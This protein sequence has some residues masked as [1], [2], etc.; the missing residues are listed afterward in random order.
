MNFLDFHIRAWQLDKASIKVI[1]HCSPVGNMR[2][3]VTIFYNSDFLSTLRTE[4]SRYQCLGKPGTHQK[5]I[6]LGRQL[7][8][9]LFPPEGFTLLIRSLEKLGT[10]NGLRIRLCLDESLIDLPWEFLYR[11]D[12]PTCKP[13]TGFLVLNPK[14]S[15]V[16]EAP[17]VFQRLTPSRQQERLLFAGT[18]TNLGDGRYEDRFEVEK[19]HDGISRAL[20]Q[21]KEFLVRDFINPSDNHIETAL[22]EPTAI[23]HYSGHTDIAEEGGYLVKEII[24]SQSISQSLS[25]EYLAALL[26][27][28]GTK[29]AVFSACNS[30]RWGFVEPFIRA[31]IPALIGTQGIVS[32]GACIVFFR[33]L[34]Y[35]LAIGLSLDEA[36]ILARLYLSD[37]LF[38]GRVSCLNGTVP[39]GRESCDWGSFMV[40]M[41]AVDAYLLPKPHE[42]D[43]IE[44]QQSARDVG[45]RIYVK[46]LYA[47]ENLFDSKVSVEHAHN[48]SISGFGTQNT[49][50]NT[51]NATQ[52][53]IPNLY[54]Q[55]NKEPFMNKSTKYAD[56]CLELRN[57]NE[58]IDQFDVAVLPSSELE[59]TREPVPVKYDYDQLSDELYY[60]EDKNLEL[61]D[62]IGLGEKLAERLLPPG[63]VRDLFLH[64]VNKTGSDEAVRLRL[65]MSEPKLAQLP[66]EFAYLPMHGDA[67]KDHSHFLALNPKVSIVRHEIL[68]GTYPELATK[69]QLHLA[70]AMAT[71][72]DQ[73]YPPLRLNKE[74]E[75]IEEALKEWVV[76]GITF[77]HE[78]LEDATVE[79]LEAL[80]TKKADLFHFAGH[81]EFLRTDVDLKT[82]EPKGSG[83]IVLLQDRDSKVSR[84]FSAGDLAQAL[85]AAGVSVAVLGACK[86]GRR[87][88]VSPWTGIAPVLIEKGIPAVVAMQYEVNDK[89]A[90]AFSR[91]FYTSLAAGLSI[92]EAVSAGRRAMTV[93]GDSEMNVEWGVPVLYMRSRDGVLFPR[94]AGQEPK[95]AAEIR[96]VLRQSIEEIEDSEI[97]GPI[98]RR[99]LKGLDVHSEQQLGRVS[100][101]KVSGPV[102]E[103]L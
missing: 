73:K 27:R 3:P 21:V 12:A 39:I 48:S 87:D 83:Q 71:V 74:R 92:D 30:G 54:N 57:F 61:S 100:R 86:S 43:I 41:P 38:S 6:Q 18:L 37:E 99:I 5:V 79:T 51:S 59:G 78:I 23:F 98:F 84:L 47:V 68:E 96:I 95:I 89:H 97:S 42:Q 13:L 1:V 10:D 103:D 65:I 16:R 9:L 64:S 75:V 26:Q 60:L 2:Q 7:W 62:L 31:G 14:I 34:Y 40:Y 81:G 8:Q 102:F 15:L 56:F 67:N 49:K 58:E 91:M 82:G 11:P 53:D 85:V 29:L 90:I 32:V 52:T 25:S 36:V 72:R 33:K 28:A 101:S 44:R 46:K 35:C 70:V 76:E 19:Q 94:Q 63:K 50:S 66:W 4:L 45:D 22:A 93:E 24:P 55:V 77:E 17:I 69:T 80:L 20:D 88:R